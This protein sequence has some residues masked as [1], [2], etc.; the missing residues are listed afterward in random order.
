VLLQHDIHT[1]TLT[2]FYVY[3]WP[4]ALCK[5]PLTKG[6]ISH[7]DIS[8][9]LIRIQL[10]QPLYLRATLV[11][12]LFSS[13]S[14]LKDYSSPHISGS[15]SLIQI[16][17]TFVLFKHVIL[18]WINYL[19]T[20]LHSDNM[21]CYYTHVMWLKQFCWTI[22]FQYKI[23]YLFF[24]HHRQH[25]RQVFTICS[26]VETPL[27]SWRPCQNNSYRFPPVRFG[28]KFF[29]HPCSETF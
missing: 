5:Q 4:C 25:Q 14:H 17:L 20:W 26:P 22:K 3:T 1:S 29:F 23:S 27:N 9:L 15:G 21:S 19:E 28:E 8:L 12:K 6:E 24:N 2:L 16:D 10:T 18:V 11:P 13:H 7:C